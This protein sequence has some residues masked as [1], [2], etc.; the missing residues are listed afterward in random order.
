MYKLSPSALSI[1]KD[2]PRCFWMEKNL[3]IKRPRGIFPSLPGGMD[4][5]LKIHYDIHRSMGSIPPEVKLQ[6]FS[7]YKEI[8]QMN[9]MRNSFNSGL[10]FNIDGNILTGGIDELVHDNNNF[11]SPFDY[12]TRG[13]APKEGATEG[14]Y[15][16]QADTY[17]LLLREKG[18]KMSDFA[19]FAYYFPKDTS[20][21]E[22][23]TVFNF[24]CEIVKIG[25]D[26]QRAIDLFSSALDCLNSS[27]PE[28]SCTCEY[29]NYENQKKGANLS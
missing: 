18:F 23:K 10:E 7:L 2:C 26:P 19:F 27:I 9:R 13:S 28:A 22:N 1:F 6:G 8:S 5:I 20:A 21:D 4:R 15:G 12:K 11:F 3:K 25:V 16:T 29:C 17:S 14:Y 24:N